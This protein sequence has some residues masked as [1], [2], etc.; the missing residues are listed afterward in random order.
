[1]YRD[2]SNDSVPFWMD[3][4]IYG[5]L[6]LLTAFILGG[7]VFRTFGKSGVPISVV[8]TDQRAEPAL[9]G[10]SSVGNLGVDV[11]TSNGDNFLENDYSRNLPNPDKQSDC[12]FVPPSKN[13]FEW[14]GWEYDMEFIKTH[15]IQTSP[16]MAKWM[17]WFMKQKGI[18]SLLDVGCGVGQLKTAM[19]RA[20]ATDKT[21]DYMGLDGGSNIMELEGIKS[22]VIGDEN[23]IIPHLCW[24]DASVPFS[25]KKKYDIVFSN[26]VAEHIPRSG[27][28]D[29][30]DNLTK[31]IKDD[32]Y[33][34]LGWAR[35]GQGG[36]KHLNERDATYVIGEIEKRGLIF[37]NELTNS[38]RQQFMEGSGWKYNSYFFKKNQ[39]S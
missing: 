11:D 31:H 24:V 15:H 18:K 25:M 38:F 39:Q 29:Y 6:K 22:S 19:T 12:P 26:E 1:M 33:L 2:S 16:V 20:G 37:D 10:D 21:L 7:Y 36:F 4:S 13:S 17:V 27:E 35:I 30:I 3:R 23:H 8:L 34:L 14:G 9:R 5:L 32:G 28:K